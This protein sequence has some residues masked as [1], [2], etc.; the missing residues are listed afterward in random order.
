MG[1]SKG[2]SQDE[3]LQMKEG[4]NEPDGRNELDSHHAVINYKQVRSRMQHLESELSSVLRSLRSK[5]NE[6]APKE[7]GMINLVCVLISMIN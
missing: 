6:V 5:T 1:G 4:T 7:V 2:V 3:I